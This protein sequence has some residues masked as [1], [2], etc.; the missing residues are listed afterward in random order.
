MTVVAVR[1]KLSETRLSLVSFHLVHR[2]YFIDKRMAQFTSE[3]SRGV[4]FLHYIN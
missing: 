4:F 3:V 2:F 1:V